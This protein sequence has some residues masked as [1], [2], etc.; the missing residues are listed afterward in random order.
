MP[1]TY[2]ANGI[3]IYAEDDELSPF[4]TLLNKLSESTSDVVGDI[5]GDVT[6][7]SSNVSVLQNKTWRLYQASGLSVNPIPTT[8]LTIPGSTQTINVPGTGYST[9]I[10]F[11]SGMQMNIAMDVY[12]DLYVNGSLASRVHSTANGGVFR[13]GNVGSW[14]SNL[15]TG[16]HTINLAVSATT[17]GVSVC[18]NAY[19]NAFVVKN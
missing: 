11:G 6:S 10:M 14:A 13:F 1:G 4:S 8:P 18:Y 3:Y 5:T 9:I 19:W 15:A 17:A 12:L 2:D 16:N 7:I